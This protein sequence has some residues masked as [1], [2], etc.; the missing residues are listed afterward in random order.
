M[1]CMESVLPTVTGRAERQAKL[2][3]AM[4]VTV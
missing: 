4:T 2:A 1:F 3:Q